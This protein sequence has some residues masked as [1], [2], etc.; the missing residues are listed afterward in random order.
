MSPTQELREKWKERFLLCPLED[1]WDLDKTADFWLNEIDTF[2]I[3]LMNE[4]KC[5]EMCNVA[6]KT[7][8]YAGCDNY[9]CPC[10]HPKSEQ[11][12]VST[13]FFRD[14]SEQESHNP[15]KG[16]IS[17]SH[18]G[19]THTIEEAENCEVCK[20]A[21]AAFEKAKADG[22]LDK[23]LQ[24]PQPVEELKLNEFEIETA[25]G[26]QTFYL[27]EEV[28]ATLSSRLAQQKRELAEKVDAAIE[29]N[30]SDPETLK[31][32][33]TAINALLTTPQQ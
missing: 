18:G 33:K 8:R 26:K 30:I 14:E 13:P 17:V 32:L 16:E 22:T 7:S 25:G 5:C 23:I 28:E 2:S 20:K 12:R 15:G 27:K 4:T 3:N 19:I 11:V 10:H 31:R 9:D 1:K 29:Y 24:E 21:Q 6:H